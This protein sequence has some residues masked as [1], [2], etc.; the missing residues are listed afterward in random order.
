MGSIWGLLVLP[1]VY[2]AWLARKSKVI[3]RVT[4]RTRR[5][6][7]WVLVIVVSLVMVYPVFIGLMLFLWVAPHYLVLPIRLF[8]EPSTLRP[9]EWASLLVEAT[10]LIGIVIAVKRRRGKQLEEPVTEDPGTTDDI[11]GGPRSFPD[12]TITL[13]APPPDPGA[14]G[15]DPVG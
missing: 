1:F 6:L 12:R 5:T 14:R 15:S 4:P 2:L 8:A 9:D 7:K 11:S 10:V 3:R 13:T